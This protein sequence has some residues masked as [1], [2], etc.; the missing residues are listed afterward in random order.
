M[1]VLLLF[2]LEN[3]PCSGFTML[4]MFN[5]YILLLIQAVKR[6]SS[7]ARKVK[8]VVI[9]GGAFFALGNV[10]PAAEANVCSIWF[11]VSCSLGNNCIQFAIPFRFDMCP[12]TFILT[13]S[14]P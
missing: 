6:D 3:S 9:L 11:S 14:G 10:N 5:V 12:H 13:N 2:I 8:R 1:F 7:F 4:Y